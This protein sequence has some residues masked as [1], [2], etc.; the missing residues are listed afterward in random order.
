MYI[1]V[2]IMYIIVTGVTINEG[3]KKKIKNKR[4][5]KLVGKAKRWGKLKYKKLRFSC[6]DVSNIFSG[7]KILYF[8]QKGGESVYIKLFAP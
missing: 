6:S 2:D 8:I 3:V 4:W 5:G 7:S 1:I